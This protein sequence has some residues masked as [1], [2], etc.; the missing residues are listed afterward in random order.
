MVDCGGDVAQ[1]D[2]EEETI[3]WDWD[4]L[5][6]NIPDDD[7]NFDLFFD[8]GLS[9]GSSSLS[10]DD[11][12]QYLMLDS[13]SNNQNLIS[14]HHDLSINNVQQHLLDPSPADSTSG[15]DILEAKEKENNVVVDSVDDGDD[16]VAKKRKRQMR[17]RD[18]AVRSRERKKMFVKDL[19]MKSKYY[20]AECKRL[21]ILLQCCLAENQALRLSMHN[22]K[23][24]DVSMSKQESA[25]L[26]LESL[27]LG[28]LLGFLGIIYLLILPTHLLEMGLLL[29]VDSVEWVSPAPRETGSK[30]YRVLLFHSFMMGKKCKASRSRMKL[31]LSTA[32]VI[33]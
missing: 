4:H 9:P 15:A 23:A 30:D 16:P 19:E 5:L 7:L 17:N 28:S 26:L 24:F 32:E 22:S 11:I 29:N 25:V 1:N 20:E 18:A 33:I 21:G 12:E 10:I 6:D 2:K 3:D 27:L 13:D 14:H 31:S 8:D